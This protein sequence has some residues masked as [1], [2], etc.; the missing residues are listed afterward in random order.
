MSLVIVL[1]ILLTG[2]IGPGVRL[3]LAAAAPRS[4]VLARGG[5]CLV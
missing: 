2:G 5:A 4:D 3:I 1:F